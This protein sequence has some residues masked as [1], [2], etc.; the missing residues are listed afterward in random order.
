LNNEFPTLREN[1]GQDI[2]ILRVDDFESI[3][4]LFLSD[5]GK[6]ITHLIV[7]DSTSRKEFL[8]EIF[9][10]DEKYSFL[11]R[12]SDERQYCSPGIDLPVVTF[13]K[14]KFGEYPE[15]H[16]SLDNLDSS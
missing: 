1:I 5:E 12:G 11:E 15:Y 13:C 8:K 4:E 14:T 10:N 3:E 6:K 7:D 16:T 2:E 9:T